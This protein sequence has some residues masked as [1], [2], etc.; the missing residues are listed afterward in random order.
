MNQ[1]QARI[2]DEDSLAQDSYRRRTNKRDRGRRAGQH[3]TQ[4][5]HAARLRTETRFARKFADVLDAWAI[6]RQGPDN[7]RRDCGKDRPRRAL[8]A[9]TQRKCGEC[10]E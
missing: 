1:R 3:L 10:G 2:G 9:G 7:V 6:R 8:T 4:G 5:L